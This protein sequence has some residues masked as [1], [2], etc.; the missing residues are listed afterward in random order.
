MFGLRK[1]VKESK[2]AIYLMNVLEQS[3]KVAH[4]FMTFGLS[5]E[6]LQMYDTEKCQEIQFEY[7]I[8]ML[9]IFS[10]MV[11]SLNGYE[12]AVKMVEI[13]RINV[14][15]CVEENLPNNIMPEDA[16][17]KANQYY[18]KARFISEELMSKEK[19]LDTILHTLAENIFYWIGTGIKESD[20]GFV[21][22]ILEDLYKE[23]FEQLR[24]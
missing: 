9:G 13:Y 19:G 11:A 18:Q 1:K 4:D 10:Y 23:A 22:F 20:V 14:E 15:K 12:V 5:E 21:Q 6:E 3:N 24:K 16:V 2:D 7:E 17:E 8:A